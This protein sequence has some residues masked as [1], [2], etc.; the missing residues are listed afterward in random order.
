[1]VEVGRVVVVVVEVGRVVVVV[2]EV[3]WY[4]IFYHL[5]Y[6]LELTKD[7]KKGRMRLIF[8]RNPA[9]CTTPKLRR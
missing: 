5:A 2:V 7:N 3:E 1:M 4:S 6:G 8:I 9:T